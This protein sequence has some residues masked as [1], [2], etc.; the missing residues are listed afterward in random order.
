MDGE[1][2]RNEPTLVYEMISEENTGVKVKKTVEESNVA[3][4]KYKGEHLREKKGGT[5]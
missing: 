1:E 3:E 5:T 4:T 2:R